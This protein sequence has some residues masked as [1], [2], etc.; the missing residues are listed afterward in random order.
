LLQRL[1]DQKARDHIIV[2]EAHFGLVVASKRPA[3]VVAT[4]AQIVPKAVVNKPRLSEFKEL[5]SR[6]RFPETVSGIISLI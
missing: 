4:M 3:E 2:V 1:S 5:P 6:S